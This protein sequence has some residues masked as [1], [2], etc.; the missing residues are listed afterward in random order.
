MMTKVFAKK[1][2]GTRYE[3]ITKSV[4]ISAVVFGGLNAAEIRLQ[5]A[6]FIVCLML[7]VLTIGEM[8][9]GLCADDNAANMKNLFM[10]PFSGSSLVL[11]YVASLG[12]YTLLSRTL[13]LF[14][15]ILAVSPMSGMVIVTSLLC[16]L[17]ATLLTAGVFAWKKCRIPAIL[18]GAV[19]AACLFFLGE[20]LIFPCLLAV[21]SLVFLTALAK[22]DAYAFY[23]GDDR[24][25][26]FVS[27]RKNGSVW[28]YIFRYMG[29]HKNYLLNSALMWG[30]AAVLPL[31]LKQMVET[32][33]DLLEFI[34]PIGFAI[35]CMNTPIGILLSCDISLERAVRFLPGQKRSFC[36]PYCAFV[37]GCNLLADVIY[38][39]SCRFLLGNFSVWMYGAAVFFVLQS[40]VLTVL[41]EWFFPIRSW[42]IENDLWHHPR[43][44]LVP[45][46]M[47][48]F[49]GLVG[50][51]P[52]AVPILLAVLA[53]EVIF[54][55]CKCFTE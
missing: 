30:I 17:Q 37:C 52:A 11:S 25:K 36:I 51:V 43:K 18:W 39:I 49:S 20:T 55:V 21:G 31:F 50:M 22:T 44:Y 29:A 7:S 10:L 47:V 33:T 24:K 34:L 2:F 42:K 4:F 1:L 28:V 14:A 26:Q 9:Q 8:W 46:V 27:G 41:L 15:V 12:A 6:P 53:A 13:L 32:D 23:L 16:I 48:V 3:K 54:L 38:L 19:L 5:I 45:V 40:A 35:V